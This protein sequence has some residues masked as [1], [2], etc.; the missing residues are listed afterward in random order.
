MLR[1]RKHP[2]R[3]PS[4]RT[5]RVGILLASLALAVAPV[6][7]GG[8]A[9]SQGPGTDAASAA[10]RADRPAPETEAERR[11]RVHYEVAIDRLN[12]GRTPEAIGE[13]LLAV[14]LAPNDRQIRLALAEAYRRVGRFP[15]A[16]Q[17][18]LAALKIDPNYQ[19]AHL[20]LSALYIQLQRYPEAIA[21]AQRL[22]DDPTF[23]DPWRALTNLGWAE[24]KLGRLDQ[25]AHHLQ[26]A[27]DY[28]DDYWPARLNLGILEA[29]RGNRSG[30]IENFERVLGANPGPLAE[31]EVRYRLAEL[32][33]AMGDKKTAI[34]QLTRASDLRPSGPW[35]K[36]SAEYLQ[37]L[38]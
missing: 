32:Y 36:R 19:Q 30:A 34:Q 7:L 13:L 8:C 35:S 15:E 17:H 21:H 28:R 27:V 38:Q 20:N 18:L 31:A 9:T 33:V 3:T 29:Q 25:A 1:S 11:A 5:H 4:S 22:V 12:E 14:R 24:F 37:S 16:E 23:P 2:G 6:G 26:L 10:V